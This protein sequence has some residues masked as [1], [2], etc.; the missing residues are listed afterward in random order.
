MPEFTGQMVEA[1]ARLSI[2]GFTHNQHPLWLDS[3]SQLLLTFGPYAEQS[4]VQ[5]KEGF[6]NR[7]DQESSW[8]LCS[9]LGITLQTMACRLTALCL[10]ALLG[11]A[12]QSISSHATTAAVATQLDQRPDLA[13]SLFSFLEACIKRNSAAVLTGE[14]VTFMQPLFYTSLSALEMQERNAFKANIQFLITFI[15]LSSS[16]YQQPVTAYAPKQAVDSI[17]QSIGAQLSD[18]IVAGL[19]IR[20]PRSSVPLAA[21]LL[22]KLIHSYPVMMRQL[23]KESMSKCS[24]PEQKDK[25][26]AIK[27]LLGTRSVRK[28]KEHIKEFCIKARGLDSSAFGANW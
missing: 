28:F 15:N 14:I 12:Y 25:D 3:A 24:R 5:T 23:L 1:F 26:L 13:E 9:N 20:M 18:V 21:D 2:D 6:R 8:L 27:Q 22:F 7:I 11:T 16:S 19:I 4:S 10:S 17:I